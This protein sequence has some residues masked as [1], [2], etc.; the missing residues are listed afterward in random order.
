[1]GAVSLLA[2]GRVGRAM[3]GPDGDSGGTRLLLRVVGARDLALGIGVLVGLAPA[4]FFLGRLVR[5]GLVSGGARVR[6]AEAKALKHYEV[7]PPEGRNHDTLWDI[8][9]SNAQDGDKAKGAVAIDAFPGRGKTTSV[10]AFAR[11]YHRREVKTLGDVTDSGH[12]RW[13]V[14]RVGLTGNTGMKEFNRAMLEFFAH[15]GA[16]RGTAADYARRALDC[17]LSCEVRVLVIDDL[18]F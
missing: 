16:R 5:E 4:L 8:V 12:E 6:E 9:D 14:C 2:P 15:P 13:P 11:D 17:V 7:R 10:L 1:M 18:H 3:M